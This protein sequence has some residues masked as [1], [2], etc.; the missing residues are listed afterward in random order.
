[1]YLCEHLNKI[2]RAHRTHYPVIQ[3]KAG[4]I[5]SKS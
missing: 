5:L 4:L 2:A 3:V 1:M